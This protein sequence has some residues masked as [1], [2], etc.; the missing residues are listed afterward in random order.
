METTGWNMIT[1]QEKR[2]EIDSP[3]FYFVR[4]HFYRNVFLCC[5]IYLVVDLWSQF[6]CC[7]IS[8]GCEVRYE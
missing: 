3:P 5:E 2:A 6:G 1:N 8:A 4:S 7:Y